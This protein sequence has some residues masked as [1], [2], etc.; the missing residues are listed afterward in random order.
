RRTPRSGSRAGGR[1]RWAGRGADER[2]ELAEG[3]LNECD[4]LTV[5]GEISGAERLLGELEVLIG[6]RDERGDVAG[7]RGRTRAGR[8]GRRRLPARTRTRRWAARWRARTGST[9][10]VGE[11]LVERLAEGVAPDD[12]RRRGDD[13]L[14]EGGELRARRAQ[15]DGLE[16]DDRIA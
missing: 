16:V 5:S 14:L 10:L 11:E 7:R 12:G 3:L 1:R 6:V 15:V 13:D 9:A 2:V 4:L 8:L